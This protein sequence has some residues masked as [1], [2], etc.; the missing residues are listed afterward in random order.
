MSRFDDAERLYKNAYERNVR[1]LGPTHLTTLHGLWNIG[2]LYRDRRQF[3]RAIEIL[4]EV[5]GERRAGAPD[6]EA[7]AA[8]AGR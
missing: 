8:A 2:L 6:A 7:P 4:E 1:I 5:G 3:E